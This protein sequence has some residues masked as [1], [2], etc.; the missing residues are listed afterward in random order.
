[1]SGFMKWMEEKFVPVAG[2]IGSQRHLAA[3]RDGF[4]GIMPIVLAGSFS[5]LLNNT[6]GAW[7]EPIG[8]ILTPI[9]G[10]VWW[11]TFGMLALLTTFS[12]AY[13]LGKSYGE[14]G[15][16]AA[17]V[18]MASFLITLPQAHGDAGWG[19]L[20]WGYLD[21]RG[22]FTGIIVA[23]IATEIFVRLTKKGLT[24]KMPD[25]VPPAVGK[26][27]ASVIPG[28]ITLFIF[29]AITYVISTLGWGSL[30]D[31]IFNVIQK[32]LMGLGQGMISVI[33]IPML[34]NLCWFFG[35]HGG[36][37][38][39]PVMQSIYLPALTENYD[40]IM[41]GLPAPHLITKSFFDS[42]VHLGGA[43]ATLALIVAV[44]IVNKKKKEYREVAKLSLA[45]GIFNINESVM[46][47]LPL[48]LNPILVIPFILIPG[49]L[50]TISYIATVLGIVPITY[51]AAPWITPVGIGAFIATGASGIGSIMAALLSVINFVIAVLIYLPFVKIAEKQAIEREKVKG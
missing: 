48:V 17:L 45:P 24:I 10:N 9:N 33:L 15:L 28:L 50:S 35:I 31:I 8:K 41:N 7:I 30:Y 34:I 3:I 42:F 5:V 20:H 44:L 12:I 2:K 6:L 23:L 25:N 13:N 21:G 1:M 32:P 26:A 49:I 18:S 27:F 29:G 22:L 16:A 37:I 36:N 11:G 39:E 4:F 14:D 19:Y 51:V 46:Y 43:G 38:F 40:A 47:G